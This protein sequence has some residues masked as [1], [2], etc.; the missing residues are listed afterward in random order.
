V[1]L[2]LVTLASLLPEGGQAL[3]AGLHPDI[4]RAWM[5]TLKGMHPEDAA[6]ALKEQLKR[7]G[8]A[9]SLRV[10]LKMLD[11][12]A[13]E[14][15][16]IADGFE[17]DLNR[18]NHPLS[19]ALQRKVVL[20]NDLLK[21]HSKCF[22]AAIQK[23]K[24]GW[25]SRGNAKLLQRTLSSA[26]EMERRRLL[27]AFR[28]YA[29]GSK[30]AW[31]NLHKLYRIARDAGVA[32]QSA[33]DGDSQHNLYV[34]SIL[35]AYAEPVQ[36]APGELDRIRFYLD[37]YAGLVELSDLSRSLIGPA[38]REGCFLI[39]N[40][41]EG[42]GRSL[43]KWHNLQAQSNDLLLD[44]GPL[45]AKLRSQIDA[46]EHG[47]LPSKIGLPTVARRPYYV[48]MLKHLLTLW[49]APPLRRSHRQHFKP[50][51]EIIAGLDNLWMLLS[52]ISLKRRRDDHKEAEEG[53]QGVDI[54]EWSV[55]NE[56]T[57][58]FALQYLNGETG[59]LSVGALAG[60]RAPDRS[61][62]H[63]CFVRR[64]VS[65]DQR[66]VELG[67]EKYAPFAVPTILSWSGSGSNQP[68]VRALVLPQV[69]SLR[70]GAAVIVP[71]NILRSGKR[72]PFVL[73]GRYLTYVAGAP[74]ERCPDYEIFSLGKP[75]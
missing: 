35:L 64:L 56:S 54:S 55:F 66:S 48:S 42:P 16:R 3:A 70:E 9:T 11:L 45:L 8:V 32:T 50:R 5:E 22:Q 31:R 30:S 19:S 2:P 23:L 39:R 12:M 40:D 57:T 4:L 68:P 73:D 71:P 43:R 62:T 47:A 36:M 24:G 17:T 18:A 29:P 53:E 20:G 7:T 25:L 10:R 37:R 41:E 27:L 72:V 65:G 58:G 61:R 51:V 75:D 21:Y 6:V 74:V 14:T 34:K 52:G 15:W 67:L 28:A 49:G 38:A 63:I 26:M 60:V 13:A 33:D 46:I 69:P 44:C 1:V 59:A